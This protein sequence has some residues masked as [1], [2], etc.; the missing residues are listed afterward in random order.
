MAPISNAAMPA[1]LAQSGAPDTNEF[2]ASSMMTEA[3]WGYRSAMSLALE[4]RD[5]LALRR[6][7]DLIGLR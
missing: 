2:R 6:G 3:Y 7:A 4:K 1:A 5:Q